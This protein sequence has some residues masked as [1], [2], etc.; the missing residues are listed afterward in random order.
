MSWRGYE[1]LD[2]IRNESTWKKIKA[3]LASKGGAL[4]FEAIKVAGT[5]LIKNQLEAK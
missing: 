2:H 1:L 3:F 4:T 5:V